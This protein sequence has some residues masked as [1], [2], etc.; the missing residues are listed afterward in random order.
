MVVLKKN[1][2]GIISTVGPSI[3]KQVI[4]MMYNGSMMYEYLF[5]LF[6][7]LQCQI[8]YKTYDIQMYEVL[9]CFLWYFNMDEK[10][11]EIT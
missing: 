10:Y 2:R 6:K 11:H 1:E 3:W 4:K 5:I 8:F 7:L 9:K